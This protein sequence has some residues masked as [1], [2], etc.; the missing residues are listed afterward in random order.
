[1]ILDWT[2]ASGVR[3]RSSCEGVGDGDMEK[4]KSGG[5]GAALIVYSPSVEMAGISRYCIRLRWANGQ[6]SVT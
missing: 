4:S 2:V 6:P 5:D 3:T 1:M